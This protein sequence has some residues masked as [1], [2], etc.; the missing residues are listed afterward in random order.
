MDYES[1][2][3]VAPSSPTLMSPPPPA[4]EPVVTDL[5]S[6]TLSDREVGQQAA[7]SGMKICAWMLWLVL[8]GI[9]F[10]W[11]IAICALA[12]RAWPDLY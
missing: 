11:I 3:V 4:T 9:N 6:E 8:V 2:D 10:K 12:A 1:Y 7:R 5:E